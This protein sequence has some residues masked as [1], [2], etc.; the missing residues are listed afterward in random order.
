M[1]IGRRADIS[2][3]KVYFVIAKARDLGVKEAP[4]EL[5]EGSNATDDREQPIPEDYADDP[6]YEELRSF[7]AAQWTTT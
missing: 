7:L 6:T 5:D 2:L 4:E 3:K 1:G